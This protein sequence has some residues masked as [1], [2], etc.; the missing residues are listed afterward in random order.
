MRDQ[1]RG[2]RLPISA[3]AVALAML[4]MSCGAPPATTEASDSGAAS[5]PVDAPNATSPTATELQFD[6]TAEVVGSILT[7]TGKT[8]A[9]DGAVV[10]FEVTDAAWREGDGT[11]GQFYEG[12][13]AV[14]GGAFT[15]E[16]DVSA[17]QPGELDVW[18]G[19]VPMHPE[20]P[21]AVRDLY[22]ETGAMMTGPSV[23]Q[24]GEFSQASV[25]LSVQL[26]PIE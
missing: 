16:V 6:A 11:T 15:H 5:D 17:F 23:R 4:T 10:S 8:N 26:E 22:G 20:Q 25:D 21:Q 2:S 18:A 1:M 9:P 19:L 24:V 3:M 7:I 12:S 13:D 14:A